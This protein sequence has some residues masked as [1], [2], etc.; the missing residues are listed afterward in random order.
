MPSGKMIKDDIIVDILELDD[1]EL[2]VEIGAP[3]DFDVNMLAWD[4]SK[5]FNY[6]NPDFDITNIIDNIK[7]KRAFKI[8][9]C[10]E[11][12][13]KMISKGWDIIN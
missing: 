5:L 11:R 6:N 3:L 10:E 1:P 12:L 4:G 2:F 7:C 13:S 9:P 8:N